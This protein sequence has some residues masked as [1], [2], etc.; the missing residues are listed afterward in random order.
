MSHAIPT[1]Y[2]VDCV[3]L[4][5][6]PEGDWYCPGCV[7][8]KKNGADREGAPQATSASSSSAFV[9]SSACLPTSGAP[10]AVCVGEATSNGATN[11]A[12]SLKSGAGNGAADCG[13]AGSA[14]SRRASPTAGEDVA[15]PLASK[16]HRSSSGGGGGCGGGSG[17]G[18]GSNGTSNGG[19]GRAGLSRSGG[20]A[21]GVQNSQRLEPAPRGQGLLPP[22]ELERVPIQL[23]NARAVGGVVGKGS[24]VVP[25]PAVPRPQRAS[26]AGKES[27]AGKG[28]GG[29]GV[30]IFATPPVFDHRGSDSDVAY[31]EACTDGVDASTSAG[32]AVASAVGGASD[33]GGRKRNAAVAVR[34]GD[35]PDE[36]PVKGVRNKVGLA[37]RGVQDADGS[38]T[39]G[40]CKHRNRT[41]DQR[42]CFCADVKPPDAEVSTDE[43]VPPSVT[44]GSAPPTDLAAKPKTP[45]ARVVRK[46]LPRRA[47]TEAQLKAAADARAAELAAVAAAAAATKNPRPASRWACRACATQNKPCRLVCQS[48]ATYRGK[49]D[50]GPP[51]EGNPEWWCCDKCFR[52]NNRLQDG[53]VCRRCATRKVLEGDGDEEDEEVISV[54]EEEGLAPSMAIA[55][56]TAAE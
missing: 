18:A 6:V 53:N 10:G 50:G 56:A 41:E 29:G 49:E 14:K 42:C 28:G 12:A 36:T 5:V 7:K 24:K 33:R 37:A 15:A 35:R 48:C 39:C 43:I 20:G 51:S 31:R 23:G 4:S 3:G 21:R 40:G 2:H 8:G 52:F 19:G 38:W 25:S 26:R 27:A 54:G 1:V 30:E 32:V 46:R 9:A 55:A 47:Y 13:T 17:T 16:K 11:D 45:K 44:V 34:G 22:R